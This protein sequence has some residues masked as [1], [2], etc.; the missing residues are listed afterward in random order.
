M[1]MQQAESLTIK[2]NQ[3]GEEYFTDV[4]CFGSRDVAAILT[5]G[6][7]V[8]VAQLQLASRCELASLLDPADAMG[9]DWYVSHAVSLS[10]RS[11]RV[12]LHLPLIILSC[13]IIFI[14]V[15]QFWQ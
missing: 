8:S 11:P 15:G 6:I 13:K 9:R 14:V 10:R 2:N 4:V 3:E 7:D 5:L 12:F 1:A